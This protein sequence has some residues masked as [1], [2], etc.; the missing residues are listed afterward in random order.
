MHYQA[1]QPTSDCIRPTFY[2]CQLSIACTPQLCTMT[3]I[4]YRD[5][6]KE[7]RKKAMAKSSI[8][9][10]VA[11]PSM[12]AEIQRPAETATYD[13]N[14]ALDIFEYDIEKEISAFHSIFAKWQVSSINHVYYIPDFVSVE[15]ET[16]LLSNV[17]VI[18]YE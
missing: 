1:H 18:H 13:A 10:D 17:R 7:A 3:S 5:M 14:Y 8:N 4:N 16:E 2:V 6:M 9:E 12:E 11:E 15:E